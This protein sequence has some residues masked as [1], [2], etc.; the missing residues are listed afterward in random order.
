MARLKRGNTAWRT[1][2]VKVEN[3]SDELCVGVKGQSNFR[4]SWFSPKDI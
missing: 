4:D 1:E 2:L 3:F